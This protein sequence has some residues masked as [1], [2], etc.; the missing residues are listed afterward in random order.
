LYI[1]PIA[2]ELNDLFDTDRQKCEKSN[3]AILRT[4]VIQDVS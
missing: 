3:H 1:R 2:V 4:P